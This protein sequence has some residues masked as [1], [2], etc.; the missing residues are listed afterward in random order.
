MSVSV[1]GELISAMKI[2]SGVPQGSVI[3]SLLFLIYVNFITKD[4]SGSWAAFADDF[5]ISVLFL[6]SF[7][8]ICFA[9]TYLLIFCV[10]YCSVLS[11]RLGFFVFQTFMSSFGLVFV[12]CSCTLRALS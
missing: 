5:K 10:C 6:L 2:T 11:F 4:V 8:M 3:G 7:G 1:T 9:V 12:E